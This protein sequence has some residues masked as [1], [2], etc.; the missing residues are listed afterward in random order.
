MAKESENPPLKSKL[1]AHYYRSDWKKNS[2]LSKHWIHK[3]NIFLNFLNIFLIIYNIF[4]FNFINMIIYF[5]TVLFAFKC[6]AFAF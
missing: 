5:H 1:D 3:N 6:N 2:T 4:F